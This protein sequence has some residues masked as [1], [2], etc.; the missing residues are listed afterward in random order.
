MKSREQ[1]ND[2]SR[3]RTNREREQRDIYEYPAILMLSVGVKPDAPYL[4]V[5]PAPISAPSQPLAY[6]QKQTH[7]QSPNPPKK[8]QKKSEKKNAAAYIQEKKTP[9][10]PALLLLP[11]AAPTH[12]VPESEPEESLSPSFRI[13][14]HHGAC[15]Y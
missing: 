1:R 15:Y 6:T 14:T 10:P 12:T 7:L 2:K 3:A 4:P 9:P 5:F 11:R 8:N 13:T